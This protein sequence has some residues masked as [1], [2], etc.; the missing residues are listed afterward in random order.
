MQAAEPTLSSHSVKYIDLY[1][2]YSDTCNIL[3]DWGFAN[4][5]TYTEARF[6]MHIY[7]SH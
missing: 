2:N 3:G 4:G 1:K 6:A 7:T 5:L